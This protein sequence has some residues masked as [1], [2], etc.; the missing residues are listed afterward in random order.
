MIGDIQYSVA[1]AAPDGDIQYPRKDVYV[2]VDRCISK[3]YIPNSPEDISTQQRV[4]DS[5]RVAFEKTETGVSIYIF[6]ETNGEVRQNMA[7]QENVTS[8]VSDRKSKKSTSK[9]LETPAYTEEIEN[10][11]HTAFSLHARCSECG[12]TRGDLGLSHFSFNSHYGACTDC[13]GL[14]MHMT[15]HSE[16]IINAK[17]SISE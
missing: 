3:K 13:H 9:L 17:F 11:R 12:Y 8:E 14:G 15:F 10:S 1:D 6:G 4:R 16:D 7:K 2:V 5:L